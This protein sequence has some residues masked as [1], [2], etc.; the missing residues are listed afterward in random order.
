M[1]KMV[2]ILLPQLAKTATCHPIKIQDITENENDFDNDS[3][4]ES[5]ILCVV[6]A[7]VFEDS[8]ECTKVLK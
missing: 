3:D 7:H 4:D 6:K 1:M 2:I 8:H 5:E